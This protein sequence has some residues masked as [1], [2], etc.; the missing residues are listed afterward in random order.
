V[1]RGQ[2]RRDEGFDRLPGPRRLLAEAI[3]T[4]SLTLVAAGGDTV[5]RMTAGEVSIAARAVAPALLVLAFI[6]AMG[7]ASGA[8][9]NPVVSLSF[10]LRRLFPARWLLPYWVAQLAGAVGAGILLRAAFGDPA[11]AGISMPHVDVP[12]AIA[13]EAVLTT[14]LLVA[15]LG[16]ADRYRVI[17]PNAA[18]AVAG[19]IALDGL[20]AIPLTGASMNPARSAGPALAWLELQDLGIYF[21]GPTIGALIAVGLAYVL[22]G[23]SSRDGKAREAAEG[24]AHA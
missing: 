12:L 21:V 4:L 16:T 2:P 24:E 8:H 20:V 13:V 23:A 5:A 15:V 18:L 10:T 6:Y 11:R 22:H 3:G 7:D 9:Y 17:G 14:L 1:D 19:V